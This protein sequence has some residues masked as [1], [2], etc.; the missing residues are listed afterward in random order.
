MKSCDSKNW[1]PHVNARIMHTNALILKKFLDFSKPIS[2][3]NPVC[4]KSNRQPASN[5]QTLRHVTTKINPFG[6]LNEHVHMFY[7]TNSINRS[8]TTHLAIK[9]LHLQWVNR[10]DEAVLSLM[11]GVCCGLTCVDCL[12]ADTSS[13]CWGV[14]F[15]DAS[16]AFRAQC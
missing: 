7:L 3:T 1:N 14:K 4:L 2:L 8:H 9:A 12:A 16:D 6:H 10:V 11:R 5:D 13:Q 15:D